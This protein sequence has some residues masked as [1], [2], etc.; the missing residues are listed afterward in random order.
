MANPGARKGIRVLALHWTASCL[1]IQQTLNVECK[2]QISRVKDPPQLAGAP[3]KLLQG[4]RLAE[5][6][7]L[8]LL[9]CYSA[10]RAGATCGQVTRCPCRSVVSI[11]PGICLCQQTLLSRL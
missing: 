9:L 11:T 1:D 4:P 10:V 5:L 3:A 6:E 2:T 7:P 8:Q